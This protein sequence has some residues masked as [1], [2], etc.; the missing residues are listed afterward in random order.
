MHWDKLK[1]E[2][3]FADPVEHVVSSTI[4]PTKEYDTLYE[5]QNNFNHTTW[6]EFDAKY[7]TGFELKDDIT[8]IDF[9]K[10]IIALWFF[11]ERSDRDP[12]TDIKLAGKILTYLANSILITPCK[13]IKIK[14]RNKFFPR[15]PCVQLD[16]DKETFLNI[17]KD[18]KI[19][20]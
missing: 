19:N 18:L 13:Q 7:R 12:G 10:E 3:Y 4:F 9:N 8:Q 15:R 16:I 2:H 20:D 11:R 5:N 17:K 6:K 1:K 14:E